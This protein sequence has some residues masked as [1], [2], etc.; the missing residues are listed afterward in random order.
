MTDSRLGD[1]D[2]HLFGEGRHHRLYER[3]GAH[4]VDG[5]VSFAVWAPSARAVSVTGDFCHWGP[6]GVPLHPRGSSGVWEGVVADAVE[7]Q[8]YKFLVTAAS[9]ELRE[10][11]DPLAFETEVPPS[12]A[13]VIHR[14]RHEWNDDGVDARSAA[15]SDALDRPMSVYEVHLGSWRRNPSE[16][17]RE[18]TYLELADELSAYC[19]DMGFTHVELLPVMAHP[20]AGS[21]GYQVTSYFAPSP[22]GAHPT[23]SRSSSTACT[24]T[25]SA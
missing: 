23:T 11:A 14:S 4:V 5:G 25:G 18:L 8:R 3:L 7:G 21:W 6:G 10:K 15:Q 12:T 17:D 2:L 13:S 19:T 22:R 16:D 1:L 9:G 24:R 20:F